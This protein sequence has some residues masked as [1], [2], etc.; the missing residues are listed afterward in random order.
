MKTLTQLLLLMW[1]HL[2]QK[3]TAVPMP[4]TCSPAWHA[5]SPEQWVH[6]W[7]RKCNVKDIIKLC[8]QLP[9]FLLY[10]AFLWSTCTAFMHSPTLDKVN[11][12]SW[13]NCTEQSI[14]QLNHYV[15]Y[16]IT[17][18]GGAMSLKGMVILIV[19]WFLT[20]LSLNSS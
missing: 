18:M 3:L 20:C 1:M 5:W 14:C 10:E 6:H 13:T 17:E 4:A 15:D 16:D 12:I 11:E 2:Q 19:I 9:H 7:R 8:W